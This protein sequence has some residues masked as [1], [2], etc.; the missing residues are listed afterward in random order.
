[1]PNENN[2][3]QVDIENLFKQ[4]VN[5]LL[6]IKELYS[7]LEEV[8][9]KVTQIKYIDNTLVKKIKKEYEKLKK[10]ILDENVQA[11]LTD[12]IET[13]IS[14]LGTIKKK[15]RNVINIKEYGAKGD[16]V[17]DDTTVIQN[18]INTY[19]DTSVIYVPCG[20]Y[21]V[22][23]LTI[24]NESIIFGDGRKSI[25]KCHSSTTLATIN[26]I[27]DAGNVKIKDLLLDGNSISNVHGIYIKNS[28]YKHDTKHKFEN[29]YIQFYG[30]IG[31]NQIGE[32]SRSCY[33]SNL[34][35]NNCSIGLH[36]EGTDN[37][38]TDCLV[39]WNRGNGIE[40]L[41][42]ASNKCVNNKCFAN[43]GIGFYLKASC[44]QVTNLE[45]Q[46]NGLE[47]VKIELCHS[48]QF[49]DL[50]SSTNGLSNDLC[51]NIKLNETY[52][53][54]MRGQIYNRNIPNALIKC[55]KYG[56]DVENSY[57][58]NLLFNT[59]FL[60]NNL[61]PFKYNASDIDVSNKII[62]NNV[63]YSLKNIFD[64]ILLGK[65]SSTDTTLSN[66]F[67]NKAI[68]NG[69]S[70]SV[71]QVDNTQFLTVGNNTTTSPLIIQ[72][73]IDLVQGEKSYISLAWKGFC[74]DY[75]PKLCNI[76]T[77]INLKENSNT[78]DS[79]IKYDVNS[80]YIKKSIPSNVN[81]I[82]INIVIRP[83]VTNINKTLCINEF[84]VGI[85]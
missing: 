41:N 59:H 11:K 10:I 6:S 19:Y 13:I 28:T 17:T 81:K 55:S 40:I 42:G 76:E 53:V 16:G 70:L 8:G 56:L 84:L 12:D 58:C 66:Y 7:K 4:N 60:N 24:P 38:I 44:T 20:V 83:K 35:I 80:G 75:D 45:C 5:D 26:I 49:T 52:E 25:L 14:Q 71:S 37:F 43:D 62:V 34:D 74:K 31:I 63:D 54:I 48:N 57:F 1:M 82:E 30:G 22:R 77:T 51:A 3:M 33:Y 21:L 39:Y 9:E 2:K 68:P 64:G 67:N 72:K 36:L 23:D 18:I 69:C 85:K 32:N 73:T 79:A 29:L 50:V 15:I 47:G 27:N 65:A 46:D 78:I 61:I